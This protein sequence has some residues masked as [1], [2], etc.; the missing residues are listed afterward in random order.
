MGR[1]CIPFTDPPYVP[2]SAANYWA[3]KTFDTNHVRRAQSWAPAPLACSR[4][5]ERAGVPSSALDERDLTVT[6]SPW[7]AG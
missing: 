7:F 6:V 1:S 4:R 5:A 2:I 3:I